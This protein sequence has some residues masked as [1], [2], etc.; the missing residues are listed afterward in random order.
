MIASTWLALALLLSLF[1][2]LANRK[3]SLFALPVAAVIAAGSLWVAT[4]TPR[5][6][7]PPKGEYAVLGH[8][9]VVDEAI[10]LLLDDGGEPRYFV[11]PYSA[12]AANDLQDAD[13]A[14][15]GK[16]IT[17]KIDGTDGGESY[18]GP[19]PV[20]AD[21]PKIPEQPEYHS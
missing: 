17:V 18:D 10:Y 2:W 11:L 5:I 16:G 7:K 15:E 8:K 1:A 13:N 9:I 4:G 19:P 20:S 21:Q 14:G 6:S 3:L 12:A